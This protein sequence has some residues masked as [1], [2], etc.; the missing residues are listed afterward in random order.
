[1]VDYKIMNERILAVD[2]EPLVLKTIEKALTKTG[3]KVKTV[4][5]GED[6]MDALRESVFDLLIMDLYLGGI[7]PDALIK[8][9]RALAPHAR[10]LVVSGSVAGLSGRHFL[11]KPF[12]IEELRQKVR[13]ILDEPPISPDKDI[14]S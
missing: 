1:M 12:R 3:Y 8:R 5:S 6:C 2:D 13:E 14:G 4:S 11:Q 9:V 10:I 7:S